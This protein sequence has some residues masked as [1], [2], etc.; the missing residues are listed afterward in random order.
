MLSS[1]TSSPY[2]D[3]PFPCFLL[4]LL[5]L[6]SFHFIHALFISLFRSIFTDIRFSLIRPFCLSVCLHPPSLP[7]PPSPCHPHVQW[8]PVCFPSPKAIKCPITLHHLPSIFTLPQES[9]NWCC[10]QT[11]GHTMNSTATFVHYTECSFCRVH[12]HGSYPSCPARCNDASRLLH[13]KAHLYTVQKFGCCA[14]A[15]LGH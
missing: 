4:S 2:L 14:N 7:I 11:K 3:S 9:N 15:T 8:H 6:L 12:E 13:I 5:C 1:F 10:P